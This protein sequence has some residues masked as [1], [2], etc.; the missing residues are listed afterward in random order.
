[1][2]IIAILIVIALA[3]SAC[4]PQPAVKTRVQCYSEGEVV[5]D[6]IF[7]KVQV[8]QGGALTVW[9]GSDSAPLLGDCRLVP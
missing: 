8:G 4:G 3:L 6:Y 5:F 9:I 2:R 1:M 7:D